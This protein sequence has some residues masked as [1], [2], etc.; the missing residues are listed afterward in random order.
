MTAYEV[1]K[2]VDDY[3]SIVIIFNDDDIA[4]EMKRYEWLNK[5]SE[6]LNYIQVRGMTVFDETLHLYVYEI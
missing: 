3:I 4:G 1:V 2:L 6:L 5:F